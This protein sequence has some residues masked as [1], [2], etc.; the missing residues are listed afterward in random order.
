M[1]TTTPPSTSAAV[2][3]IGDEVLR[4]EITNGNAAFLSGRLFD[5]GLVLREHV[6]V[7]DDPSDVRGALRRLGSVVDVLLVTG[8]LG[9]TEDDRTVDVV[10]DLLGVT[11]DVHEPSRQQME[12]R[13]ARTGYQL[14]PNNLRQVRVPVGAAPLANAVG[15]APGFAV[16]VGRARAFFMPGVPREMA[17]IFEDHVVPY[18]TERLLREGRAPGLAR[19]WH[20]YGMG[21][22]HADHRLAGL[23]QGVPDATLHFRVAIPELHVKVV[24]SGRSPADAHA[25]LE[26]LDV[27]VRERLGDVVHG[28]DDQTFGSSVQN[29]FRSRS[30]TLALAESCTGGYAA[31][32]LTAEPGASDVFLGGIISYA[33]QVKT[34]V[35]GVQ[36]E[37]LRQHGAVSE[38]CAA[39]MAEGAR[40]TTGATI[41]VSITGVAGSDRE[42]P[43][44]SPPANP[45]NVTAPAADG[46]KPVGM[47]CFG[48]ASAA[49]TRTETKL[50]SGGRERIRRAAAF[51]ALGL[52]RAAAAAL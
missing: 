44:T 22:S 1:S 20:I 50:F 30:A 10:C 16:D 33:N 6:V 4:G 51:H 32:L 42:T 49:G 37:T 46:P 15:L 21:E 31:Q 47:V 9:P 41:A 13:F 34:A 38:P 24:L 23:L 35:L 3:A 19:T 40:R 26:R 25:A 43:F 45:P 5:L 18:L 48:V 29:A 8:G 39:E 28:I 36:P 52:A 14:T 7:S 17:R 12:A 2:L 27:Q 11:S